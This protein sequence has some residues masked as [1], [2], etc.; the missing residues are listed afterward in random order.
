MRRTRRGAGPRPHRAHPAG[1]RGRAFD[2]TRTSSGGLEA[3]VIATS[4]GRGSDRAKGRP[5][6]GWPGRGAGRR[7]CARPGPAPAG[8]GGE[9][10]RRHRQALARG[11]GGL[12]LL[13]E[14]HAGDATTA[15]PAAAQPSTRARR[16]VRG[17]CRSCHPPE[18]EQ[19]T[20]TKS[21]RRRARSATPEPLAGGR[22]SGSRSSRVGTFAGSLNTG[23][24][25][26]ASNWPW[27]PGFSVPGPLAGSRPDEDRHGVGGHPAVGDAHQPEAVPVAVV[28]ADRAVGV[29]LA[30][31]AAIDVVRARALAAVEELAL[32]VAEEQPVDAAR[33][34]T[35]SNRRCRVPATGSAPC[36]SRG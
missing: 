13:R 10:P 9:D 8:R 18:Q 20:G 14:R 5:R 33:S 32:D 24:L 21:S 19:Q 2:G 3:G 7:P 28:G 35:S 17:A 6:S 16:R 25:P 23:W 27:R 15:A 29:E 4:R 12:G 1:D 36:P 31:G 26:K 11:G 30:A 34:A 22:G